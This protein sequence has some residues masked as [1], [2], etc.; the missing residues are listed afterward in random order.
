M[1]ALEA[2]QDGILARLGQLK[3]QVAAF[4]KSLGLP[5]AATPLLNT[6]NVKKNCRY[7][8]PLF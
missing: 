7:R 2:R 1:E 6:A 8:D 3:D 5:D 4:K